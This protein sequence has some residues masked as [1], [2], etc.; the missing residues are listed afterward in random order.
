MGDRG[1]YTD[2]D[3]ASARQ[4]GLLRP[5]IPGEN[6]LALLNATPARWRRR[7]NSNSLNSLGGKLAS[8]RSS[9]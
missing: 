1:R 4:V 3:A 7:K 2:T 6:A 8:A 5:E 9:E